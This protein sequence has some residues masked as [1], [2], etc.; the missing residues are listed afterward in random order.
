MKN[1][2]RLYLTANSVTDL[3]DMAAI[4]DGCLSALEELSMD[5]N[6]I[7]ELPDAVSK[8]TGL[9]ELSLSDNDTLETLPMGLLQCTELSMLEIDGTEVAPT[10]LPAELLAFLKEKDLVDLSDGGSD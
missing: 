7:A 5:M 8:L 3:S 10:E 1:L 9:T 6:Q 2:T 4:G